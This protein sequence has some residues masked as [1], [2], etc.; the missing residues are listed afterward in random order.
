M[1]KDLDFGI[2]TVL[3]ITRGGFAEAIP[4][5]P[6]VRLELCG[7]ALP[8]GMLSVCSPA[9][10][11]H[12]FITAHTPGELLDWCSTIIMGVTMVGDLLFDAFTHDGLLAECLASSLTIAVR[13][14]GDSCLVSSLEVVVM[15]IFKCA[16]FTTNV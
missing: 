14:T 4:S 6:P 16:I 15:G 11:G 5:N 10:F 2:L 12:A 3:S 7:A 1:N 8:G 13:C 9:P